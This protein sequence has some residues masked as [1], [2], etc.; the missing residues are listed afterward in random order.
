[1]KSPYP[2]ISQSKPID[3]ALA[4]L[5]SAVS[6]S[7]K[8]EPELVSII[9]EATAK[10][11]NPA[12][13]EAQLLGTINSAITQIRSMAATTKATVAPPTE[14]EPKTEAERANAIRQ[15]VARCHCPSYLADYFISSNKSLAQIKSEMLP[16]L[17][18][19][20]DCRAHQQ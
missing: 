15:V 12:A 10:V 6:A 13:T 18:T 3:A 11:K 5:N 17:C 2:F 4:R 9:D 20:R 8:S 1:M 14:P 19:N 16:Y 7:K